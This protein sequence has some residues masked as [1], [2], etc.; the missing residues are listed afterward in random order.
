MAVDS[1]RLGNEGDGMS[2]LCIP[3]SILARLLWIDDLA[4]LKCVLYAAHHARRWVSVDQFL[5]GTVTETGERVDWGTRMSRPAV[6][7]GLRRAV[8]H[9]HLQQRLTCAQCGEG[10]R[11]V[12]RDEGIR[13]RTVIGDIPVR[14]PHCGCSLRRRGTLTVYYQLGASPKT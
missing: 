8:E 2:S 4:E 14:C 9:E 6:I 3:A 7:Q 11:L 13:R 10:I 1:I 12:P 5:S